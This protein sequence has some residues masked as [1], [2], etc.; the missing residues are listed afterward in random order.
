MSISKHIELM[1][2]KDSQ[3]LET[4]GMKNYVDKREMS[5]P[6]KQIFQTGCV[7][8]TISKISIVVQKPNSQIATFPMHVYL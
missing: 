8:F 4:F 6:S 7:A 2:E 1:G 3:P 5:Q